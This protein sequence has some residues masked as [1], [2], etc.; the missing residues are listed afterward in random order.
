MSGQNELTADVDI[1]MA[2]LLGQVWKKK[3]IVLVLTLLT[4]AGLLF[5]LSNVAPLYKSDAR[6]II[7]SRESPFTRLNSE[8]NINSN[9]FDEQAVGSQVEI[10]SSDDLALKVISELNLTSH[11]EFMDEAG[12]SLTGTILEM[13]GLSAAKPGITPEERVLTSF[14]KNLTVY[15]SPKSRVIYIEFSSKDPVLAQAVPN[16]LADQY[17]KFIREFKLQSTEEATRWLGPE[18]DELRVKLREAEAKVAEFRSNSDI[19]IGNNNA[20]LATQ[21]LSEAASELSRIRG[22]KSAAEGKVR[23]IRDAINSGGSLDVIPEVIS[24]SLIQRLREREVSLEAQISELS[25]TLLP[26]HPRLKALKSQSENFQR[27]IRSAADNILVSLDNNVDLFAQQ[28]AVL[29]KQVDRLKAE[30]SRVGEAEVELRALERE[31]TAQR[32]LLETYLTQYREAAS[33]Q[34]REYFPVDARII[35]RAIMPANAYFPKVIPFTI[36]GMVAMAVLSTMFILTW[37]L[38]SGKAL[39]PAGKVPSHMLPDELAQ[40]PEEA[41]VPVSVASEEPPEAPP[42]YAQ[43]P[44]NTPPLYVANTDNADNDDDFISTEDI[45]SEMESQN[46]ET[47]QSA[48]N[49]ENDS[50]SFF[51]TYTCEAI[52][53]LGSARIAVVS[54][55]GDVGS[56]ASWLLA[57]ELAADDKSVV[58]IDLT[59]NKATSIEFLGTDQMPGVKDMLSGKIGFTEAIYTDRLSSAHILP[60]GSDIEESDELVLEDLEMIAETLEDAYEYVIF[61]CGVTGI[62]GLSNIANDKTVVLVSKEGVDAA[63]AAKIEKEVVEAGYS[64]V[65]TVALEDA[66]REKIFENA[67]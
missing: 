56:L 53:N 27:Q 38:M 15:A 60:A 1:D 54:P 17:M 43:E 10:L 42:L 66:D 24:S 20:L 47:A 4:G 21:Q 19:L 3:W 26:N 5:L 22:E 28:E 18:I 9:Q 33:R 62:S 58:L 12:P 61:D 55:G 36:A 16:A 64:V 59:G 49:T 63:T 35:S 65:V 52:Q 51:F 40:A 8:Q 37:A 13:F 7:E 14:I 11:P 39:K 57:R 2:G 23:A 48:A 6:I 31:A 41:A 45:F 34:N 46:Q 30:A 44:D 50:N 29:L 67:A 25:T 32:A